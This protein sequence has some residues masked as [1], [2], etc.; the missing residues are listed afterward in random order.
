MKIGNKIKELN[1]QRDA[2]IVK[3]LRDGATYQRAAEVVGCSIGQVQCV[4]KKNGL[5]RRAQQADAVE[6]GGSPALP[7]EGQPMSMVAELI[8][9]EEKKSCL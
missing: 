6:P 8:G 7:S 3:L 2:L 1:E 4:A 9:V 5:L